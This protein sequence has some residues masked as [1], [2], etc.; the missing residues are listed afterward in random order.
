MGK[1][2]I[3]DPACGS[4]NFLYVALNLLHSLERE[5]ITSALDLGIDPPEPRVHPRQLLGIEI[6]EYA[7]QLASVVVWIG[8]IQNEA[9][10][11]NVG[12]RDP[13]LDPLDNIDCRDAIVDNT[14]PEPQPAEWPQVDFI[15]G[16]PP[17]LGNKRMRE[18]MGDEVVERIYKVWGNHVPNGADLCAYWFENARI[19]ITKNKAKRAGLLA[20]QAI[21]GSSYRE[22]IQNIK[23]SGDIFFAVSDRDWILDGAAVHI[24]MVG[25]DDGSETQ[26]SL[27]GRLAKT[28][29][30]DLSSRS[31]DVTTANRLKET[32]KIAFQGVIPVGPFD[33]PHDEATTVLVD[34]N[35]DGANNAEVIRPLIT[36]KDV[37]ERPS[38]RWIID[39]GIDTTEDQAS[40]YVKPFEIVRER[41]IPHRSNT[42]SASHVP[43][44]IFAS[45]GS[46][47]RNA[48]APL[49]RYVT[50]PRHSKHRLFVWTD[51]NTLPNESVVIFARH[52]DYF[53]GVLQSRVHEVWSRAMGTQVRDRES[54]FRY[55]HTTCFETFPFPEPTD[56]QRDAIGEVAKMMM[57]HRKNMLTPRENTPED[58]IREMTLNDIYNKNHRWLQIDHE[59]LD[60]AVINAY[61]WTENP[62][63]LDDDTILE[64]LLELNLSRQPA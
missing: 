54:G 17:F 38:N 19:Q 16:N 32:L 21:R 31:A 39:F 59:K 27:D 50:T 56:E 44:W 28:I 43:W 52:D 14:G 22:V 18:E 61:N 25:F 48:I 4:G 30:A 5:V 2:R 1:V 47:L 36:A 58:M 7:H 6:D 26:K 57:W 41:V 23:A 15:V 29:N 20:T 51:S 53:I 11:G 3:L 60:R 34:N 62:E 63:D 55:T 40:R 12:N 24:S 35:P 8:H 37:T 45:T 42:T 10:V 13:I 46:G 33:I 64:R 9:R 49:E